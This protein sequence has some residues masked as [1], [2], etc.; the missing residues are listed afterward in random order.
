MYITNDKTLDTRSLG[1]LC[2]TVVQLYV[3]KIRG[4]LL[5]SIEVR[6]LFEGDVYLS[7]RDRLIEEIRYIAYHAYE[8]H[9]V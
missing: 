6:C 1:S 2:P 3:G 7:A 4:G 9:I 8:V 5:R